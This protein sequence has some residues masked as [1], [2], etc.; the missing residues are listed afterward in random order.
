MTQGPAI[1]QAGLE[2]A[3]AQGTNIESGQQQV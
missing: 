2:R 3:T 1:R